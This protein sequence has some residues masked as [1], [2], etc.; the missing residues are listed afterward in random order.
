MAFGG[1]NMGRRKKPTHLKLVE[2]S[3]DR[4]DQLLISNE[5]LAPNNL[6]KAPIH[7]SAEQLEVW[8]DAV[9]N[10]P[11]GLLKQIDS[12]LFE[13][14]V[15][16]VCL[17]REAMMKLQNSSLL[18]KGSNGAVAISPYLRIVNQQTVI[19]KAL[20]AEFGFSPAAR[21]HIALD[22]PPEDDPADRFFK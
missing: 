8:G 17:R 21:T 1:K 2:N 11:K 9:S 7:L 12:A 10:A 5:P 3:R 6:L 22:E 19:M 13:A 15:C 4:R 14:W 18:I 16:A 20:A